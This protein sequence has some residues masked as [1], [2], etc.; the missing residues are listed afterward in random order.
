MSRLERLTR[1][2]ASWVR[3]GRMGLYGDQT[4]ALLASH[5]R[6]RL[7]AHRSER[8]T[9]RLGRCTVRF[10]DAWALEYLF[11]EIFL[12][13]EYLFTAR[14]PDPLIV[15]CGSNVGVSLAFFKTLHPRARVVCFEPSPEAYRLLEENVR[16]NGWQDDVELHERAV[17]GSDGTT[18]L[19][20]DAAS[21][22]RPWT[23]I[24][25]TLDASTTVGLTRLSSV[26]DAPVD[27]LKLDVEGAEMGVLED[28][29]R[30]GKLA[31]VYEILLEF[32]HHLQPDSP[33]LSAAC[34]L[35][36]RTGFT[37]QV[38]A[39]R[40][41]AGPADFQDVLIHAVRASAGDG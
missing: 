20:Y 9:A 40:A 3:I 33:P 27:L 10:D 13:L 1:D 28:L 4:G 23:S 35:L 39:E 36:E 25:R 19:C 6:L 22:T 26:I 21:P 29:E 7:A 11:R 5:I 16:L 17:G 24:V 12:G 8:G 2:V 32:H 30:T 38:R 18:E 34:A 41:G 37:Y 14:R 15:D 31:L